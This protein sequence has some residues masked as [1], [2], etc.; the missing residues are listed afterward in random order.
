[1]NEKDIARICHEVNRA[2]CAAIGDSTQ[3]PWDVLPQELVNSSLLGVDFAIKHPEATPEQQHESWMASKFADGWIHGAV[4]DAEAKTHPCLVPYDQLPIE[5][6]LKDAL[7]QAVVRACQAIKPDPERFASTR[8]LGVND[9]Q[10]TFHPIPV[11]DNITME[12]QVE[13]INREPGHENSF[14]P[15]IN[16]A[17]LIAWGLATHFQDVF[18][19]VQGR[20]NDEFGVKMVL[21]DSEV[22][23][24][25]NMVPDKTPTAQAASA[26]VNDKPH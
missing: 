19:F 10:I 22:A 1:M 18:T 8:P 2:Y 11:G 9:V 25:A 7:F 13:G 14:N 17:H 6:R 15:I 21:P 24:T 23:K 3:V 4:K 20:F 26:A 5:Q 16:P 12:H